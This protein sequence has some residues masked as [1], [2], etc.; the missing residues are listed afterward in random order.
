MTKNELEVANL[1]LQARVD[2]L[3]AAILPFSAFKP[4]LERAEMQ[5]QAAVD[6]GVSVAR[7]RSVV[8]LCDEIHAR[9]D[10]AALDGALAEHAKGIEEAD[11]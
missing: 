4:H 1:Q 3:E 6:I 8:E 11:A 2:A 5:R 7:L 9:D 10:A